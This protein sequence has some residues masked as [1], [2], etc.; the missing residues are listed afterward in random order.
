MLKMR[1]SSSS[2]ASP[3]TDSPTVTGVYRS[4]STSSSGNNVTILNANHRTLEDDRERETVLVF[5]DYKFVSGITRDAE[6]AKRLWE[7]AVD[8]K[9][10]RAGAD[11]PWEDGISEWV[12]PYGCVILLCE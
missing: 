2:T 10:G 1:E 8:P 5:P 11:E 9:L 12:L 6:G 4:S 7:G 3:T